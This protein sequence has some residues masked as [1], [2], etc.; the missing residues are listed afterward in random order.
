MFNVYCAKNQL[1]KKNPILSN[2]M[3]TL[4]D[5]TLSLNV[6]KHNVLNFNAKNVKDT[7]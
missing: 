7:F 4:E 6:S 3:I 5:Q 2:N 1:S